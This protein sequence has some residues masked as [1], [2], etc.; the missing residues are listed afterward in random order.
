MSKITTHI[1][2]TSRGKPAAGVDVVLERAGG[3]GAW[4][5]LGSARTDANGR[6]A[7]FPGAGALMS[8]PHRL[9]FDVAAYFAGLR[10]EAFFTTIEIVF[11]VR[12][13]GEHHHVPLLVSPFGYTTYRGS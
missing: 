1:L 13:P 12:A 3:G 9:R 6:I 8:G 5:R 10:A 4:T 7:D 11:E 2:D